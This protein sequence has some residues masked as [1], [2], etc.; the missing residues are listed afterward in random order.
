MIKTNEIIARIH[1]S[2][3]NVPL[4]IIVTQKLV[5]DISKLYQYELIY[6]ILKILS[7]QLPIGYKYL[8]FD[9]IQKI[10]TQEIIY[11]N[12]SITGVELYVA[13]D[14]VN[15]DKISPIFSLAHNLQLEKYS[16]LKFNTKFTIQQSQIQIINKPLIYTNQ[17]RCRYLKVNIQ[18]AKTTIQIFLNSHL[19]HNIVNTLLQSKTKSNNIFDGHEHYKLLNKYFLYN[20]LT[21]YISSTSEIISI[22]PTYAKL[23]DMVEFSVLANNNTKNIN[24]GSFYISSRSLITKPNM[25]SVS[26][27]DI[28]HTVTL[29]LIAGSV[30]LTPEQISSITTNIIILLDKFIL[31]QQNLNKVI[32]PNKSQEHIID[33]SI[34]NDEI[35]LKIH[36][37]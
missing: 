35:H 36:K 24:L 21:Q 16:N 10:N 22:S 8:G 37:A 32:L 14:F 7:T 12:Q 17:K 33:L 13:I 18:R 20:T 30:E 27:Q 2:I 6:K 19:V 5:Q 28:L 25:R 34:D 26:N 1:I 15:Y 4:V 29:P 31:P 23:K 3:N 11:L 9:N